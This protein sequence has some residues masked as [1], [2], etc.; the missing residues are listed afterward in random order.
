MML[1]DYDLSKISQEVNELHSVLVA[2]NSVMPKITP[3]F[4]RRRDSLITQLVDR[5]DEVIRGRIQ[6]IQSLLDMPAI[7]ERQIAFRN[8]EL[9]RAE[10]GT[11]QLTGL[12]AIKGDFLQ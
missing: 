7:L 3:F 10:G 5:N 11:T 8:A 4:L 12:D 2:L 9:Q 6:E 1:T